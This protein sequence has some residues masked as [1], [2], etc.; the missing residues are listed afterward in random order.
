MKR[1]YSAYSRD[2]YDAV[3]PRPFKRYRRTPYSRPAQKNQSV[4]NAML[5]ALETKYCGT[6]SANQTVSNA[7]FVIRLHP[8]GA[9]TGN[10]QIIGGAITPVYVKVKYSVE[11]ADTTNT[12][13]LA[14]VQWKGQP[15][16][17][18]PTGGN[19]FEYASNT[20]APLSAWDESYKNSFKVLAVRT[21]QL[22]TYHPT[23]YGEFKIKGKW[24]DRIRYTE[25]DDTQTTNG[26]L[27]FV[28]IS[29]SA[30][31][32]HPLVNHFG[33]LYYKDA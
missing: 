3:V 22:D 18:P 21:H 16:A 5:R 26:G 23:G 10:Q 25:G 27:Y 20:L 7:G 33:A 17:E 15:P 4:R 19:I 2:S 8:D 12:M 31:A 24:L 11:L 30:A 6:A 29:D 32:N 9:G 13:T 14:V 28:A 1:S